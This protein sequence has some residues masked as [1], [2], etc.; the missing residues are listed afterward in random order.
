[1]YHARPI[2]KFIFQTEEVLMHK[3]TG[4]AAAMKRSNRKAILNLLFYK[5]MSKPELAHELKL[6]R[7]SLGL[8]ADELLAAGIVVERGTGESGSGRKP[9]LLDINASHKHVACLYM[10]R[11]EAV[12]AITDLRGKVKARLMLPADSN[13]E[14]E[15]G[16]I[17]D[18]WSEL[19]ESSGID[20]DTLIYSTACVPGPVDIKSGVMLTP[21]GMEKWN[22]FPLG[23][24]LAK[25]TGLKVLVENNAASLALAEMR[26]G[27][28]RTYQN[29]LYI[30]V[31]SGI[32]G[33]M[34]MDGQLFKGSGGFS[35]EI[36]H[37]SIYMNG[38]WC[39]CGNNGCL[40][41]YAC[42]PALLQDMFSPDEISSWGQ[43]VDLAL[44]GDRRCMSVMEKEADYLS[45]ALVNYVNLM[46]PEAI[47]FGGDLLHK[48]D[49]MAK[50]ITERVS[51]RSITRRNIPVLPSAIAEDAHVL[52]AATIG[53]NA[54]FG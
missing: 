29:F 9:M 1:M 13:P 34:I 49:L 14:N 23:E 7:A 43:V 16:F 52:A 51:K 38:R 40:E 15:M 42:I 27:L 30:V 21:P 46:E 47:V 31:D 24:E 4:N 39:P 54:F 11:S 20:L 36:G 12:I 45:Q 2:Y 3:N 48:P 26:F 18:S 22:Q 35:A 8:H 6:T 50:L 33:G 32:G 25:I 5:S 28:G 44:Q 41:R 19:L 37:T 10:S 17:R 53:I